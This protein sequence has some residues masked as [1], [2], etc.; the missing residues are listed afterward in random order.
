MA[1]SL[2][3][4]HRDMRHFR[5]PHA[6]LLGCLILVAL[7]AVGGLGCSAAPTQGQFLTAGGMEPLSAETLDDH[8]ACSRLRLVGARVER[9]VPGLRAKGQY[10]LLLSEEL[11][12][13]SLSDGRVFVTLGLYR[14]LSRDDMLAAVIAHELAHVTARHGRK[15]CNSDNEQLSRELAADRRGVGY[16]K[17]AGYHPEAM[18]E[19]LNLVSG[20]LRP[21]WY[22]ARIAA[23]DEVSGG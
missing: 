12:A 14:H 19:L 17:A 16:L 2:L 6:C 11:N 22:D 13:F 9:V 15:T 21:A 4:Y 1:G 5:R 23:L 8:P 7:A 18:A 3:A 10:F 20:E